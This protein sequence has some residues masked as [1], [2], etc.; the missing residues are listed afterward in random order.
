MARDDGG[1]VD[2]EDIQ[3]PRDEESA[4]DA[5]PVGDA[6]RRGRPPKGGGRSM[7]PAAIK[8]RR[9]RAEQ[10][11]RER[12][13]RVVDGGA[14]QE[15]SALIDGT[16]VDALY[17]GAGRVFVAMARRSLPSE[18][19]ER[20]DITSGE[21]DAMRPPTLALMHKYGAT[22]GRWDEE[23]VFGLA[24]FGLITG[25]LSMYR[26]LRREADAAT[27]PAVGAVS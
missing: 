3:V 24:V 25:K 10:R 1:W 18:Y 8:A 17:A 26:A 15:D 14:T 20:L 19:A 7:T 11:E 23:I 21:R 22:R 5:A 6:P 16:V 13:L 4:A 2:A 27:A 9:M 12:G